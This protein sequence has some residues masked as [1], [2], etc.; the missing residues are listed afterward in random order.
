MPTDRKINEVEELR[1]LIERCT[2]AITADH[3]GLGVGAMTE[4]RR[5]MRLR[6]VQFRVVKN[7]LTYLA[8]DAAGRPAFKEV[9]QGPTGVAFGFDDP[10]EPAKALTDFITS[11]RSVLKI[12]GGILGDR[13]LSAAEVADLAAI[14]SKDQLLARLLGRM[15]GPITGLAIVLNAPVASLA[16]VLQRRIES[17]GE[18]GDE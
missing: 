10:V 15:Q 12:K 14:P 5:A 2:A 18:Q 4:L 11:T 7:T 3:T 9:V 1:G 17:A 6:G 8:A 13:G 16:R